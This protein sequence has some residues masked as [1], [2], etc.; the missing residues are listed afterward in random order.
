MSESYKSSTTISLDTDNQIIQFKKNYSEKRCNHRQVK[1]FEDASEIHCVDCGEKL[2]PVLWIM[3]HIKFV[4][5]ASRRN[6]ARLAEWQAIEKKLESKCNFMCTHCKEVNTID[7][8]R[9][10]SKAAVTRNLK[11][12][13]EERNE[14]DWTIE[15]N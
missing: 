4:N 12:I 10:P 3:E 14:Q 1:F 7:F 8:K 5:Q 13:E 6:N 9:L 15:V 2:N 11:V